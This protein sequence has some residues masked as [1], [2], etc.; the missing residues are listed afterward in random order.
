MH[1][2]QLF[3]LA[4]L[5]SVDEDLSAQALKIGCDSYI[6]WRKRRMMAQLVGLMESL[7]LTVFTVFEIAVGI[8]PE[9]LTYWAWGAAYLPIGL[10]LLASALALKSNAA[11]LDERAWIL[12]R[13][14]YRIALLL[15][16]VYMVAIVYVFSMQ[17]PAKQVTV[18]QFILLFM[19]VWHIV[20]QSLDH[21]ASLIPPVVI[22]PAIALS[23][24]RDG[25][26]DDAE[27]VATVLGLLMIGLFYVVSEILRRILQ[28]TYELEFDDLQR[29]SELKANSESMRLL[30]RKYSVLV[31]EVG[32]DLRQ[33][34]QAISLAA[35]SLTEAPESA[36]QA[37][38][39]IESCATSL[40]LALNSMLDYSRLNFGLTK[41]ERQPVELKPL[42]KRI[43]IEFAGAAQAKGVVLRVESN[44]AV[45]L[46]DQHAIYRI[47]GNL[48]QNALKFTHEGEVGILALAAGEQWQLI[49]SDTGPGIPP[50]RQAQIFEQFVSGD[51]LGEPASRGLGLGLAIAQRFAENMGARLECVSQPHVG[52]QFSLL[53]P[54]AR[55]ERRGARQVVDVQALAGCRVLL[56]DDDRFILDALAGYLRRQGL[57]VQA[58]VDFNLPN[59]GEQP[60]DLI[61]SDHFL[62]GL[63]LGLDGIAQI[64]QRSGRPELPAILLTGDMGVHIS[65]STDE[66]GVLLIHK[67]ASPESL[68]AAISRLLLVPPTVNP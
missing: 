56:V 48:I 20:F 4:R 15:Q 28:S 55:L 54:A 63:P 58:S 49:V 60:P 29:V 13:R 12:A 39:T 34:V 41:S 53:L 35:R 66:M 65:R 7:S 25:V 16:A 26:F 59:V 6:A 42:F 52:T 1:L 22:A 10:L 23:L 44:D 2:P 38:R 40:E 45:V 27:A 51:E 8:L 9:R 46:A 21:F 43:E 33:P 14:F 31:A 61:V 11:R 17:L 62:D 24:Y 50:E 57:V 19:V 36:G 5:T 3:R 68:L 30:A 64:R 18:I 37:L 32:H 67:P 47:L